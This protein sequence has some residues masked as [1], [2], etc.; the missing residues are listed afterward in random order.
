MGGKRINGGGRC[1]KKIG[2]W[3]HTD[4]SWCRVEI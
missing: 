4:G 2:R 3:A 1:G